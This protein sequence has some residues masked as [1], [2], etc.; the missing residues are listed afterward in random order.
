M[1]ITVTTLHFNMNCKK[2]SNINAYLSNK[3]SKS[4]VTLTLHNVTIP[5]L[6]S[7]FYNILYSIKYFL[8]VK[9]HEK[10]KIKV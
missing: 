3:C 8:S 10:K 9:D 4:Y 1:K 2:H 5:N 6:E 7:F